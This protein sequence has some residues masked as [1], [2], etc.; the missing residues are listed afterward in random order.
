MTGSLQV[1]RGIYYMTVSFKDEKGVCR[2][3]SKSTGI[4]E[5]RGSKRKAQQMLDEYLTEMQKQSVTALVQKDRLFLDFMRDW[6]NDVIRMAVRA[7][8]FEQYEKVFNNNI[9]QYVPFQGVRLQDMTPALIQS[10]VNHRC[11]KGLSPKTMRKYVSNIRQSLAYAVKLDLISYNPMDRVTLPKLQRYQGAVALTPEQLN[12]LLQLFRGDILESVVWLAVN[13]GMRRSEICGLRWD[14]V[15]FQANTIFVCHTTIKCKGEVIFTDNTKTS[16]S[17]RHLPI[18]P[19]MRKYLLTV[20]KRQEQ[21]KDLFGNCYTDS[22]YVCTKENGKPIDPDFVTHHFQ[23]IL[24]ANGFPMFRF[25]DLR[26]SAVN[27]LRK[28]GCDAKDIQSFLGHSDVSTTLNI[29]GH[30][31]EGDMSRMGDVM[32]Q[33]LRRKSLAG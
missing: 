16:T 24:K 25:H 12:T 13:Y 6:L 8:T 5:K 32:D 18:T 7:N 11:S 33:M 4:P 1:K 30:L 2:Q 20:K 28:G 10:Y 26:H 21:S 29:Y 27:T 15:D 31:M 14:A 3:R 22:G 23:R 9:C 17:R 19:T